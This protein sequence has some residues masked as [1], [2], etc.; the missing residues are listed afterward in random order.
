MIGLLLASD[1]TAQE[2]DECKLRKQVSP[3]A[4][5]RIDNDLFS[6]Q[7]KGYT[8]GV[9]LGLVSPNLVDYVDDPCLPRPA[10]WLNRYLT[11]LQ[12]G[13]FEQQN[14]VAT[15]GQALYTPSDSRRR[16]LI[17]DDR[18]YAATLLVSLGYNARSG[19]KLRHSQLQ[20]GILGPS[21]RG[22]QTQHA[23]HDLFEVDRFLGWDNQLRDEPVFRLVHER[24]W[25]YAP[26]RSGRW[27][28][29][30][31]THWGGSLGNLATYA[32]TGAELRLGRNLPDDF[33]STPL[34]PAGENTAPSPGPN[35]HGGE[36][37]IHVFFTADGRGVVRD[38]T[39]DG[40]T[41]KDSHHVD[42]RAWVADVGYGVAVT[43]GSWKFAIARYNRTREFDGQ[44]ESPEFG[45]FTISRSL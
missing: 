31:I 27:G 5:L 11:A 6:G 19:D 44:D 38:I 4:N 15:F 13:G 24:M 26:E 33:G 43:K 21:A 35:R 25:R 29:D 2:G 39:L 41:W 3:M 45:S 30:A 20:F 17:N 1:V 34:R 9:Q 10:R 18:P 23:V 42:K 22:K 16:D 8:S 12:P 7:D 14:M 37:G 28:W 36:F 40:N 32:N